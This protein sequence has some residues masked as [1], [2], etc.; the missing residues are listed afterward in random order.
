[1]KLNLMLDVIP[2]AQDGKDVPLPLFNHFLWVSL[3]RTLR[4]GAHG[5]CPKG[6]WDCTTFEFHFILLLIRRWTKSCT[7]A[8]FWSDGVISILIVNWV[9]VF[10]SARRYFA[11]QSSCEHKAINTLQH[12]VIQA[13]PTGNW[14]GEFGVGRGGG[15]FLI[16]ALPYMYVLPQRV[17]FLHRFGQKKGI[18]F[19]YFCLNSGM[20]FRRNYGSL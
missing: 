13:T 15:L 14:S 10:L 6:E 18:D 9:S 11:L 16:F 2:E 4:A 8:H 17:W 12:V 7:L 1:M 3:R 20:V 5:V 19:A